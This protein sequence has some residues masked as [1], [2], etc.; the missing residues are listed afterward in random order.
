MA[1]EDETLRSKVPSTLLRKSRGSHPGP[2]NPWMQTFLDWLFNDYTSR[3]SEKENQLVVWFANVLIKSRSPR[4]HSSS[5]SEAIVRSPVT[6]EEDFTMAF[7][8]EFL[9]QALF[10]ES[11]P[12]Y[13]TQKTSGG[14]Q[15]YPSF[16]AAADADALEKAIKAKGVDEAGIIAILTKR[17]NAQRQE[18]KHAYRQCTGKPLDEALK[19]ALA[20][21][22][23]DVVLALL[24]T[25]AEFDAHELKYAMK[26]LG[27]DEDTL[28]EIL[29]SRTNNEL[30][31]IN[32]VYKEAYKTDLIKDITSDTS[33]DFRKVLTE[34]AKG[35]RSEDTHVNDE[36]ADNDARAMYEAGEKRK[37]ADV[38]VFIK[39][40]TTRSFPQL[41]RVFQRYCKYSTHEVAKALDLELKGDIEKC[42]TA[43]VKCAASRAAY[44][45]ERLNLAMKGSG[46]RDKD[47]IRVMVSRAEIDMNE[48]KAHYKR[49][50]GKTLRNAILD[51]TKGDYETILLALTGGDSSQQ[52]NSAF[53]C[54]ICETVLLGVLFLQN[55]NITMAF[56]S[57]FLSQARFLQ[58]HS[59]YATQQ[60]SGGLNAFPG[61]SA[62]ADA[63]ALEK[64]MKAKGV[65]EAGIIDI[66]TKRNNAQ[67]Q[68]IKAEYKQSTGKAI[69]DSLKKALSCKFEEV[70]LCLLKTPAE[71]DAHELKYAT[72]GIGTDEEILNE[73]L[74]SRTNK[75]LREINRVYKEVFKTE[76]IKDITSD[77]SGD[78]QKALVILAKG[79]RSEEP[80][81]N[82]ELAD[83][84]ARAM[85]EAGEQKKGT[86]VAVF[87]DILTTRS[88]PHL[89]R[90]FQKYCKYS[91]HDMTKALL[92]EMKGDIESCLTAI[93]KCA[94]SRAAFFA[95]KLNL[96]MKG[97]GTRD[98]TLI[99]IMVS[100]SEIDMNE[101]KLHY[102]RLYKK[103]LRNA[104]LEETS[105]DYEAI[106][107]AL[108]GTD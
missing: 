48:I 79:E 37:G 108:A 41:Q 32:R 22:F 100:R 57:E 44:F 68:A 33:G 29:V 20:G 34:L 97:S 93:V 56:L 19:K 69:E 84:D 46:T 63:T 86:D 77:T 23:E 92:L 74:A 15:A 82:E 45:A 107:L 67:R 26:G 52:C 60:C 21:K 38:T 62:A 70:V 98:K 42:L 50:Y 3:D 87:T 72:K 28:I 16:S 40:L 102:K 73:I 27:T 85:F 12:E 2:S 71:F 106:L 90:V 105:G 13:A 66:L 99:R 88:F 94:A 6:K 35:Q 59:Q 75:E 78:F 101:I 64:A 53:F 7:L 51:E 55:H 76:L 104:I 54:L 24:K 9:S 18:I 5:L 58:D 103:T 61:F 89:Q 47:L 14:L 30:R 91:K 65:N 11:Q 4:L 8:A 39:L 25:P 95:E 17:N 81:V 49:I 1:L 36:L 96:A 83:N 31:E 43:I 10:L 80:Y